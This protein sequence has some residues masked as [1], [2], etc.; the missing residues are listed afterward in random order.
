MNTPEPTALESLAITPVPEAENT[1]AAPVRFSVPLPDNDEF[2][3]QKPKWRHEITVTLGLL[4]RVHQ[5]RTKSNGEFVARVKHLAEGYRHLPNMSA[6]TLLRKYYAYLACGCNWRMLVKGYVAPSK[7]PPEFVEF[8]KGLI[9]QNP[10]SATTALT[11]L[12]E[13]LWP[14]GVVAIPGYGTWMEWFARTWPQ[15]P[16]PKSFP[17]RWPVGWHVDNLR[18]YGPSRAEK[19]IFTEGIG[20]AHSY[21]PSL[22]R[23]PSKLRKMEY[24]VIDDFQLDVMCAFAGDPERGLKP[25]VAY[26]GGLMAMCVGTRKHLA[27]LMGPM[28]DREVLQEDG[29]PKTVRSY[30]QA[31][32]VQALLYTLFRDH[33]LPDYT[34][35]IICE[36]KTAT[37]PPA[38]ELMLMTTFGGRIRVHRTSIIHHKTL[39]NGFI[40]GGGTPWQKGWIESDFN[41]LWNQLCDLKGYKGSN[42]RLNAPGDHQDKLKYA[43]KFLGQGKGAANLPPEIVA[44]MD[45]PF[46]NEAQLEA[47]VDFVIQRAELRTKHRFLGFETITEF[48]WPSPALPAPEGID[49]AGLN[50]FRALAVLNR[51]QQHLMIPEERKE[52]ILERWERL[53]AMYPCA[54]LNHAVLALFLLAPNKA[55]W[56]NHAVTFA[57]NKTG[58]S[59]VDDDGVM[60]E[61]AERTEVL[62]YIDPNAPAT[63]LV[64]TL[65]GK[66]LG[67]L[68]M[69]GGSAAGVDITDNEAMAEAR[70]RRAAIVNRVL[71]GVRARP[72]HQQADAALVAARERNAQI[73]AAWQQAT[74]ELPAAERTAIVRGEVA[75]R[76]ET[77][78]QAGKALARTVQRATAALTNEDASAFLGTKPAPVA[79]PASDERFSDYS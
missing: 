24:I 77:A 41:Y 18:K 7:Q 38:L 4:E 12:R 2:S 66:Q 17:R 6:G 9:E 52:C 79:T 5:L 50:T 11:K 72:L 58:Y 55:V 57:R 21:L 59:Y 61:V 36:T 43:A 8:V 67:I 54:R 40:E 22:R 64:T 28:T 65:D 39:E 78:Q 47:A 68:R 26:V 75:A 71:A 37:I 23:D 46:M 13:E 29:K 45:L 35:T 62:A 1:L 25:Q 51:E 49:P 48:R 30:V 70:A 63:A 20:A 44:E 3:L 33:G 32:D 76:V 27:R 34:V 16:V 74:A 73:T 10:R 56:R 42:E 31:I 60:T 69:L 53:S 14:S 15:L 19:K